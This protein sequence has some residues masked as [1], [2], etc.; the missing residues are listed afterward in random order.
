[1]LDIPD[2]PVDCG[3]VGQPPANWAALRRLQCC[4]Y[5]KPA[6]KVLRFSDSEMEQGDRRNEGYKLF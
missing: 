4:W 5:L 2:F 1:M 3:L 6:K